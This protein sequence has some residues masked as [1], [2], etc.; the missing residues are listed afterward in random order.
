MSLQKGLLLFLTFFIISCTGN[1]RKDGNTK[2]NNLR[3]DLQHSDTVRATDSTKHSN[4]KLNQL[5]LKYKKPIE[6]YHVKIEWTPY[7]SYEDCSVGLATICFENRNGCSFSFIDSAFLSSVLIN[8]DVKREIATFKKDTVI[9]VEYPVQSNR[10][11]LRKDVPFC[12]ADIDFDGIKE[13]VMT[14]FG[15]GQRHND[16]YRVFKLDSVGNLIKHSRQI[17]YQK[18]YRDFDGITKFVQK[19]KTVT[20]TFDGGAFNSSYETF[21]SVPE[22]AENN[23]F[24]LKQIIKY[25][26]G[27]KKIYYTRD[28][29]TKSSDYLKMDFEFRKNHANGTIWD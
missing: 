19:N 11:L 15:E 25:V 24:M 8:K 4:K 2:A 3:A 27:V 16:M 12:F 28:Q 9:H 1:T 17:T 5:F 13:L 20:N 10:D 22:K 6:G 29:L 7:E 21:V 14:V 26:D 23:K 18:P